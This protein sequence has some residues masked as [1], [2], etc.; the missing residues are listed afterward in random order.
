VSAAL[1]GAAAP[2]TSGSATLTIVFMVVGGFLIG[3]AI[4]FGMRKHWISSAILGLLAI[5]SIALAVSY[6]RTY[7]AH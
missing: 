1:V 7:R 2:S 6:Y 3:G 4:S 5:G